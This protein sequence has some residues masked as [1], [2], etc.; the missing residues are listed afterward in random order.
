MGK[1]IEIRGI[2]GRLFSHLWIKIIKWWD[3]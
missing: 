2:H 1:K 3:E